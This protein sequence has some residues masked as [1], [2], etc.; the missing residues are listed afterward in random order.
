M[1]KIF[2]KRLVTALMALFSIVAW[3]GLANLRLM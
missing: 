1:E 3:G 2:P